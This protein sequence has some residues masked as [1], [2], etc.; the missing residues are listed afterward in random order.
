MHHKLTYLVGLNTAA[1]KIYLITHT[2]HVGL[3]VYVTAE[4]DV[5]I[6][7]GTSRLHR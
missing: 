3:L 2:R 4:L 5:D 1:E 7:A 6:V